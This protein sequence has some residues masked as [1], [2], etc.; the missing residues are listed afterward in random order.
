MYILEVCIGGFFKPGL[1]L[2]HMLAISARHE[3]EIEISVRARPGS[4][5]NAKFWIGPFLANLFSSYVPDRLGLSDFYD[6]SI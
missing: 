4:K 5:Q 3:R 1:G 6:R 2:A